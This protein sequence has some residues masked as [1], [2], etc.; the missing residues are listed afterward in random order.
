MSDS[1]APTAPSSETTASAEIPAEIAT[2]PLSPWTGWATTA[3][4]GLAV[5]TAV[6]ILAV[7][8]QGLSLTARIGPLYRIG[9]AFGTN[10]NKDILG[11]AGLLL[12]LILVCLPAITGQAT[13]ASQDR[14][15]ALTIGIV[16][17]FAAIIAIASMFGIFA[18]LRLYDMADKVTPDS[19]KRELAMFAVRRV[20]AGLFVLVAGLGAMR[21]RLN[22]A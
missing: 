1:D 13:T 6:D 19:V 12:A 8:A 22:A 14:A 18:S 10:F 5:L 21:H 2:Y 4:L 15:A 7:V 3:G 11:W 20:G 17:A 9:F 16:T